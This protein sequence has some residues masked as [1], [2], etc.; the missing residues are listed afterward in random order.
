MRELPISDDVIGGLVAFYSVIHVRRRELG[1][2]LAE[3][4]RVLKPGGRL[5]LSAHEGDGEI[6]ADDFLGQPAPFVATCYGLS[7]LSDA[8][9]G[10]GLDLACAER[11]A[12]YP[13]EHA[14][15]RLYVEAVRPR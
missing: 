7:E 10:A 4:R 11:R 6:M 9:R 5:L 8:V 12:P 14:T 15:S 3:F 1:A 2:L 13:S